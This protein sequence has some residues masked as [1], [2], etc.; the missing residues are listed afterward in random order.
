MR[1]ASPFAAVAV[2]AVTTLGAPVVA[3]GHERWPAIPEELGVRSPLPRVWIPYRCSDEPVQ[4][5]YHGAYYGGEP[6][7]AY[8]GYTYP[9]VFCYTAHPVIPRT[10]LFSGGC[11]GPPCLWSG[12]AGWGGAPPA[13]R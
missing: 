9:P 4:N 2:L 12:F 8:R 5:F 10:H 6:P 13:R 11:R 3:Q 7:A 1:N